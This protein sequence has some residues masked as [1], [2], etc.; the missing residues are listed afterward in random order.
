MSFQRTCRI[1]GTPSGGDGSR[2]YTRLLADEL[3]PSLAT[4][5]KR[6]IICGIDCPLI[7]LGHMDYRVIIP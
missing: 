3:K 7:N 5:K 1:A 2:V 4:K 6:K